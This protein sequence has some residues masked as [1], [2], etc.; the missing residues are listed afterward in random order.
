MAR[1]G[2]I[3]AGFAGAAAGYGAGLVT[4]NRAAKR[5]GWQGGG[6]A[7][8]GEHWTGLPTRIETPGSRV[9]DAAGTSPSSGSSPFRLLLVAA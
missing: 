4:P 6:C 1:A 2:L 7:G 5:R 9:K 3:V 8:A